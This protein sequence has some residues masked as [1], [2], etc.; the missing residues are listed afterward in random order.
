MKRV[1]N[2]IT[3]QENPIIN[4]GLT[5]PE[6]DDIYAKSILQQNI[7]PQNTATL[8]EPNEKQNL[9]NEKSFEEDV[10]GSDLDVPGSEADDADELVGSED[11]ENNYYSVGGD[12]HNNLEEDDFPE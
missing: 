6:A 10:S 12:N 7:D 4:N 5:Y 2:Q 11:E 3:K 9:N 1:L 8:K